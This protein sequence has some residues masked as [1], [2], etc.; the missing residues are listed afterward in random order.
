MLSAIHM[1]PEGKER[2]AMVEAM[3]MFVWKAWGWNV[4]KFKGELDACQAALEEHR[5]QFVTQFGPGG[6]FTFDVRTPK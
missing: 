6:D 2:G 3:I 4:Q 5:S 1:V